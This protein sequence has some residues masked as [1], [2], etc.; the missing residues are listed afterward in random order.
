MP[1]SLMQNFILMFLS[2]WTPLQCFG[3][4]IF[5][6]FYWCSRMCLNRLVFPNLARCR[7]LYIRTFSFWVGGLTWILS[8]TAQFIL[9]ILPSLYVTTYKTSSDIMRHHQ[10]TKRR[11]IYLNLQR[12]CNLL[13]GIKP[14]CVPQRCLLVPLWLAVQWRILWALR[15]S[16]VIRQNP[17]EVPCYSLFVDFPLPRL[18]LFIKKI[19]RSFVP[20]ILLQRV[21]DSINVGWFFH[22]WILLE[23][24]HS[25]QRIN[26]L[27]VE[28]LRNIVA[29]GFTRQHGGLWSLEEGSC[30]ISVHFFAQMEAISVDGTDGDLFGL[31][32]LDTGIV[33]P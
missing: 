3:W 20:F 10:T 1:V 32:S 19:Q 24:H 17:N 14:L 9:Y 33:R 23:F 28:R 12:I 30:Y 5:N 29:A 11:C 25:H 6:Q 27:V 18:V 2:F 15:F 4:K 16:F 8:H 26:E 22:R 7:C 13:K 21:L 31:E